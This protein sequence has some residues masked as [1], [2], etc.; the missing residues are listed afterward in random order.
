MPAPISDHR[1]GWQSPWN[2]L[3]ILVIVVIVIVAWYGFHGF[4]G[5]GQP[6]LNIIKSDSSLQRVSAVADPRPPRI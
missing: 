2:I 4:H 5:L 3:L 6:G 1:R